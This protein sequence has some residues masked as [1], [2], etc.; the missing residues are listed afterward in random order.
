MLD[1]GKAKHVVLLTGVFCVSLPILS[2]VAVWKSSDVRSCIGFER[3]R[4]RRVTLNLHIDAEML[5]GGTPQSQRKRVKDL[6]DEGATVY[7]CKT[8]RQGSY[9]CKAL[10]VDRRVLYTGSA[11]F[12]GK[13]RRNR[14]TVFRMTG[15]VVDQMLRQ[16]AEDRRTWKT[17]D[18]S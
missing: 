10:V 5:G 11:N 16:L 3:L 6:S 2:S 12:T 9:H 1:V 4:R 17:W 14:E 8:G 13:S 15:P 7:V 18:G